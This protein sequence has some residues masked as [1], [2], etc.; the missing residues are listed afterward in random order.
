MRHYNGGPIDNIAATEARSL[1]AINKALREAS[2]PEFHTFE[3]WRQA[4][5]AEQQ[6]RGRRGPRMNRVYSGKDR[7]RMQ[8][9]LGKEIE[10]REM[11]EA[12]LNTFIGRIG[13]VANS[14]DTR[15]ILDELKGFP[16]KSAGDEAGRVEKPRYRL[17]S[18]GTHELVPPNAAELENQKRN[19]R[20]RL[21]ALKGNS[22]F[23][24]AVIGQWEESI[25]DA[26]D[27][28]A[29]QAISDGLAAF[30]PK[31]SEPVRRTERVSVRDRLVEQ[32]RSLT[33][34]TDAERQRL[35]DRIPGLRGFKS[36]KKFRKDLDALLDREPGGAGILGSREEVAGAVEKVGDTHVVRSGR[37]TRLASLEEIAAYEA[38][39]TVPPG[40]TAPT[41]PAAGPGTGP[42]AAPSAPE[43]ADPGAAITP[44]EQERRRRALLDRLKRRHRGGAEAE[45][46]A[47]ERRTEARTEESKI[48]DP[49]K[50]K[51]IRIPFGNDVGWGTP[52]EVF[53]IHPDAEPGPDGKPRH[54]SVEEVERIKSGGGSTESPSVPELLDT[55]RDTEKKK[56]LAFK[57][58]NYIGI[59]PKSIREIAAN[60]RDQEAF[61]K[62]L[63]SLTD[64]SPDI[65]SRAATEGNLTQ[66]ERQLIRYAQYEHAKR[67]KQWE[68]LDKEI[69]PNHV[70]LSMKR[71]PDID[72]AVRLNDSETNNFDITTKVWKNEL[73]HLAMT[74]HQAFQRVY[75]AH[76]EL[77]DLRERRSHRKWEA[78]VHKLC[79]R[80]GVEPDDYEKMFKL[81]RGDRVA[82]RARVVESLRGDLGGM[83][84]VVGALG[85][86]RWRA[87]RVMKEADRLQRL[88][89]EGDR[90]ISR[91][92]S[93]TLRD[94]NTHLATITRTMAQTIGDEEKLQALTKAAMLNE[95]VRLGRDTGP[96]SLEAARAGYR[97]AETKTFSDIELK[98]IFDRDKAFA[99]TADGRGW[100]GMNTAER[101][102]WRDNSWNPPEARQ[103]N[104]KGGMWAQIA[105]RFIEWL[106]GERKKSLPV[107]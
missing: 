29:I 33:T 40:P 45:P 70:K 106:F 34:I 35:L 49:K 25:G 21:N 8:H 10:S 44:D 48:L 20:F 94:I 100:E 80:V 104:P 19:L 66:E 55:G 7:E 81:D 5:E 107:T 54:F 51:F 28:R 90:W 64:N 11:P 42:I 3:E 82:T 68:W 79:D 98:K 1:Q 78:S 97:E 14:E 52:W 65:L 85:V 17:K 84:R 72:A 99:R 15:A 59:K 101:T 87:N 38:A 61:G 86:T 75:A 71:N 9:N 24:E 6:A 30:E 22:A 93:W 62:L 12:T 36:I 91:P 26:R 96:K 57:P 73:L 13:R 95:S 47:A 46:A 58:E 4:D 105:R 89:T 67:M 53:Y 37:T 83:G 2:K 56:A 18:D 69:G 60:P 92:T 16:L 88:G 63:A 43:A 39:R 50:F 41:T 23:T 102:D 27:D 76:T 31:P 77:K 74:D 103:G 32:V